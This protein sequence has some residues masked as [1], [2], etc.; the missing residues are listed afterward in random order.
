MSRFYRSSG[1]GRTGT[2]IALDIL[3]EQA[4]ATGVVDVFG[5]VHKL[6]QQRM[7]MVQTKVCLQYF[8]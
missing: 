2:F 5:C 6:R 8:Y 1:V 4:M 3:V 7:D